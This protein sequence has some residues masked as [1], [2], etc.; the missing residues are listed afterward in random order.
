MHALDRRASRSP[1]SRMRWIAGLCLLS[2]AGVL[3]AAVALGEFDVP[4]ASVARAFIHDDGSDATFVI[5]EL[6]LP[7]LLTG[8]LAGGALGLAGAIVQAVTRNPLGEPGLLG[9]TAGAAFATVLCMTYLNL[10]TPAELVL[11]TAGG[12]VAATITLAIG[13]G[14]RLD[15]LYLTLTGMSVNLFFAAAIILMLVCASVEVN[16]IY[17]WLTGSLINRTWDHVAMLWP[18]VMSGLALGLAFAGR[19]DALM[20]DEDMLAAVGMRVASWRLLFGIIAVL[21]TAATVAATGPITFVGLVAPHL[22]RFGLGA[23]A[24]GH[25]VLLPLSA[26][27]GASLVSA[28]DLIAKWQEIP[29]GI[30]CV[31]LGG[32][33]LVYLIGKREVG[34]A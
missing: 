30:L 10:S 27:V 23:R 14:A 11:G 26:W 21:L 33:M 31:L 5:R 8:M 13:M 25:R 3:A 4:L 20:L 6:R 32:P 22:V 34:G 16:G 9:V 7:R 12:I 15:P 29:V 28:A 19:L 24:S 17:Y 18:W 2:A 1:R